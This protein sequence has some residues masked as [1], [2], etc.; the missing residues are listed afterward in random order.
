MLPLLTTPYLWMG[1]PR[2]RCTFVI[3]S[4]TRIPLF[5]ALRDV[6]LSRRAASYASTSPWRRP[7]E[8]SNKP[9]P[10]VRQTLAVGPFDDQLISRRVERRLVSTPPSTSPTLGP[11][12]PN[13]PQQLKGS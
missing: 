8:G 3:I 11:G 12:S 7:P 9:I 1:E 10:T 2:Q 4:L 13:G 6:F 5:V